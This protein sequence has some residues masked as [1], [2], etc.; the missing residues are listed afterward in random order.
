[1]IRIVDVNMCPVRR[2]CAV[3][4]TPAAAPC[5]P[6]LLHSQ[7]KISILGVIYGVLLWADMNAATPLGALGRSVISLADSGSVPFNPLGYV[8]LG[9]VPLGYVPLGYVPLEQAW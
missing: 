4:V 7:S 8:P 6:V 9:Y 2:L 3:R 1:M 5:A